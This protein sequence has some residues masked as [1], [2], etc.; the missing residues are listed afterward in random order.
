MACVP[1]PTDFDVSPT[2]GF[3]PESEPLQC[4]PEYFSPWEEIGRNLPRL[5][6]DP[7]VLRQRINQLPLLD[8][9]KLSSEDE[10][11]RAHLVL[12]C[13]SHAYVWCK[14]DAGVAKIIPKCL[15]IPWVAAAKHLGIPPVITHCSYMLYNWKCID[16]SQP[17]SMKNM[18]LAI[19]ITGSSTEKGFVKIPILIELEF[20][21]GLHAVI[22]GQKSVKNSDRVGLM[23]AL[24]SIKTT[25]IKLTAI[26]LQTNDV[27]DPDE[28][29]QNLRPYLSGWNGNP[30][31]PDGLLYEGVSKTPLKYSGGS[32][33]QS[34]VFQVLDAALGVIHAD[35]S[36]VGNFLERM[37]YY[38]PPKH[39]A[40]IEAVGQ[41]PSIRH[42]AL[43]SGNIQLLEEYNQCVENLKDFRSAHLQIVARYVVIP[44]NKEKEKKQ[45]GMA[46]HGTGGSDIMPFLKQ[47]RNET[48]GALIC[49]NNEKKMG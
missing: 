39:R 18:D 13:V 44:G 49:N 17:L 8:H 47:A 12:A 3:V 35:S 28:F 33:A 16:P 24:K 43:T 7:D 9:N 34:S 40:F 10:W 46:I 45:F 38:M 4:L 20:G 26:F 37:R 30:T 21:R 5:V 36:S 15:A 27:V 19:M 2:V 6:K 22:D 23:K 1:S 14:G 32:A 48:G 41:G 25:I 31:L 11:K 42:F 29:Y